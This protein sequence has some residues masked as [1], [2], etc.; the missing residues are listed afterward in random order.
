MAITVNQ[1]SQALVTIN[2]LNNTLNDLRML[3]GQAKEMSD[4]GWQIDIG[5]RFPIVVVISTAQQAQMV[6]YY[7]TLKAR[8]VSLFQA[9]P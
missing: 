4:K 2:D 3:L 7:D 9:L 1:I 8:C 6:G 5:T